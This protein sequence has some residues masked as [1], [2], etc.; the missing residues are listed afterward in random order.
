MLVDKFNLYLNFFGF[1]ERREARAFER[2]AIAPKMMCGKPRCGGCPTPISIARPAQLIRDM[3]ASLGTDILAN[4]L[5][6]S[7]LI[8]FHE[9][10]APIKMNPGKFSDLIISMP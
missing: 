4:T 7:F 1:F 8:V 5:P 9:Q 3:I 2:F 6:S 10:K